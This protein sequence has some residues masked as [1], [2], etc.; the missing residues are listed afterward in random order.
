MLF[1]AGFVLSLA[2]QLD[3]LEVKIKRLGLIVVFLNKMHYIPTRPVQSFEI[4]Y[5]NANYLTFRSLFGQ[6]Y[7]LRDHL[8]VIKVFD[9]IFDLIEI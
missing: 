4:Q 3:S 2:I 8:R 5:L 1:Y 9:L 6:T 7:G